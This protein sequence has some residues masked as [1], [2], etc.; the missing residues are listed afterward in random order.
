M[1]ELPEVETMVRGLRPALEGQAIEAI[2][3]HDPFL[4]QGVTAEEF[5]RR[6]G[7]ASV[8][9]RVGRRGK[10]V[11]I[12]LSGKRPGDYRHPAPDDGRLLARPAR[13]AR[14][15]R[16]TFGLG[17]PGGSVW[18]CDARRLGKVAWYAGD[19][20]AEAAFARSHGPDALEI[21]ADDLAESTLEDGP[22]DQADLD[23][24]EGPGRDRQHLRR[25]G[26]VPLPAPPRAPGLEAF[27][28]GE[29]LGS[30]GRSARS[31]P[32]R[33][34]RRVRASTPAIGPSWGSKGDSSPRTPCMAEGGKPCPSCSGPI[35]KAKI[36]G[37][38]GRPTHYC[39]ICQ[40]LKPN[41][42]RGKAGQVDP[43]GGPGRSSRLF[44]TPDIG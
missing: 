18:F 37:L 9:V 29:S 30:I 16:V 32:R 5:E 3:V 28:G 26:P 8:R 27:E 17:D 38:V 34:R 11:V 31:W 23:G 42:G 14:A 13:S 20:A 15:H 10:W 35:L 19:E 22:G 39:P 25:R 7:G 6:V 41:L 4:L 2:T 21:A 43:G 12:E 1:P 40:V 36:A 24:P 33:S 44:D